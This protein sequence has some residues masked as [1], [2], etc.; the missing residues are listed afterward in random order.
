MRQDMGN[1]IITQNIMGL[2]LVVTLLL[3][4][5][6]GVN[7][8][9]GQTYYVFKYDGHY[10]AHNGYTTN[11]SEICVENEFSIEKCLWEYSDGGNKNQK[12]LKTF[13]AD[14]WLY[15]I[16][17]KRDDSNYKYYLA[18]KSIAPQ[19]GT[20]EDGWYAVTDGVNR[21]FQTSSSSSWL[22]HFICYNSDDDSDDTTPYWE[23]ITDQTNKALSVEVPV[24]MESYQGPQATITGADE[25]T[26]YGTYVYSETSTIAETSYSKFTLDETD[27]YW[28]EFYDHGT[29]APE[30]WS[31]ELTTTW[32]IEDNGGY[33]T[34]DESGNV[35]IHKIPGL[36]LLLTI[37]LTVSDGTHSCVFTKPVTLKG[38]G[39][40]V[41]KDD[42]GCYMQLLGTSLGASTAFN[43]DNAVWTRTANPRADY[44]YSITTGSTVYYL[45]IANWTG[46]GSTPVE[47]RV[48]TPTPDNV[49]YNHQWSGITPDYL[50]S[51]GGYYVYR[52]N[53][54]WN[55]T[56]DEAD[57]RVQA[58]PVTTSV[59]NYTNVSGDGVEG[60]KT[61][62]ALGV[63]DYTAD[64]SIISGDYTAYF[65]DNNTHYWYDGSDHYSVS[66]YWG[67]TSEENLTKT[68]S[69]AGGR[70]YAM[71]D[72]ATGKL[73]VTSLPTDNPVIITLTYTV[74]NGEGHSYSV[75]KNITI[76]PPAITPPTISV[77]NNGEVTISSDHYVGLKFY[78]E[79]GPNE[80]DTSVPTTK[81]EKYDGS[82]PPTIDN[83]VT[84]IKAI[85]VHHSGQ[86]EV[87]TYNRLHFYQIGS[88][89]TPTIAPFIYS[90]DAVT[91]AGYTAYIVDRI[92]PSD[93]SVVL[94]GLDYIP[95]DVPVL[96]KATSSTGLTGLTLTAWEEDDNNKPI[97]SSVTAVNLLKV[98]KAS[99]DDLTVAAAQ[100]YLYQDGE[101]VLTLGGKLPKNSF[102]MYNPNYRAQASST[103]SGA[104]RL[105]IVFDD[106]TDIE[107]IINGKLSN[108]KSSW[109]SLDG[110][111]LNGQ[112]TRKGIYVSNGHKIVV[113]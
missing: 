9:W 4:M 67:D 57:H 95:E 91:P 97:G 66:T 76:N 48:A 99:D 35:T 34:I 38:S 53:D 88:A 102:Y 49:G 7:K 40:Y 47:A 79:T 113:K 45:S 70:G 81:S 15:F 75:K 101:F 27:Y 106:T 12:Y 84:C 46:P 100:V 105:H 112:P 93:G 21:R 36:D 89:A 31:G 55:L 50:K 19:G 72:T 24:T 83:D 62:S 29:T 30:D 92:T 111:R 77:N 96:L 98:L 43:T 17:D 44:S 33:A 6:L 28:Y 20:T 56:K 64:V 52:A 13:G 3:M 85:A 5:V 108:S 26:D 22:Y 73:T 11:G 86:S 60:N 14:Y 16:S 103:G 71:F 82:T 104:A 42:Q 39:L 63:Y 25:L 87:A 10:V 51:A 8:A 23:L 59:G 18:L 65:F 61:I 90:S 109:Y 68:W 32:S 1:K 69:C 54:L 80:P 58:F 110:R 74:S 2:R 78:Y 37:Q 41:I 107:T 94:K